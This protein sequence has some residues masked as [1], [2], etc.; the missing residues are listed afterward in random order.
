MAM[1]TSALVRGCVVLDK[2]IVE[3]PCMV[4][5]KE[6][7]SI[8]HSDSRQRQIQQEGICGSGV[9]E[10]NTRHAGREDTVKPTSSASTSANSSEALQ[11]QNIYLNSNG[12]KNHSSCDTS[13]LRSKQIINNKTLRTNPSISSK[14]KNVKTFKRDYDLCTCT[15]EHISAE[16]NQ[17]E[18]NRENSRWRRYAASGESS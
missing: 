10:D 17:T 16:R 1:F 11:K 6:N 14:P 9:D 12:N 3:K 2:P 18:N 7:G 4:E 8:L 15:T 5:I 13:K